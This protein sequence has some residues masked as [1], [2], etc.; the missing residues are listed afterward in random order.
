MTNTSTTPAF[1]SPLTDPGILRDDPAVDSSQVTSTL[2]QSHF[3]TRREYAGFA[4]AG[5][6]RSDGARLLFGTDEGDFWRL[7]HVRV[8]PGAAFDDA[9]DRKL[10]ELLDVD[11]R[12][13]DV[14]HVRK[15]DAVLEGSPAA[16][17]VA[18][19]SESG[20]T[21]LPDELAGQDGHT[22]AYD[23]V[24]EAVLRS[25]TDPVEVVAVDDAVPT[26]WHHEVPDGAP[27]G[28]PGT[29]VARFIG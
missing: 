28:L 3:E 26:A 2:D 9:M 29:D 17:K 25:G 27:A 7:P 24:F 12:L 8:E 19:A 15:F 6:T 11:V 13:D 23:V 16:P 1:D 14:V 10:A 4:I 20:T 18:G 5:V 21:G 22:R